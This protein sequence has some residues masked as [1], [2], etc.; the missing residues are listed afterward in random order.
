MPMSHLSA[1]SSQRLLQHT[2]SSYTA[3]LAHTTMSSPNQPPRRNFNGSATF[4]LL[5]ALVALACTRRSSL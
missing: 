2:L 5:A 3:Q 4:E 1:S